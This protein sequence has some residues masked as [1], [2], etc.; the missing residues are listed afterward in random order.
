[1]LG[2]GGPGHARPRVGWRLDGARLSLWCSADVTRTPWWSGEPH[3]TGAP[4]IHHGGGRVTMTRWEPGVARPGALVPTWAAELDI[5]R[6]ALVP[7]WFG[8]GSAPAP[9]ARPYVV[10]P[11]LA[12]LAGA[13]DMHAHLGRLNGEDYA[14]ALMDELLAEAHVGRA[15]VSNLDGATFTQLEAN[16]RVLDL[17]AGRAS[18]RPVFWANPVEGLSKDVEALFADPRFAGLKFHPLL[19]DYPADDPRLDPYLALAAERGMFA[20]FHCDQEENATPERLARL[21]ARHPRVNFIAGHM[22]LWG[23]QARCLAEIRSSKAQNLYGD[24]AWFH[25]WDLLAAEIE[26][27]RDERFVFGSDAPVDGE[28]SYQQ[29]LWIL[30]R[31]GAGEPLLKRLFAENPGRLVT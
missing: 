23:A 19:N 7:V 18:L 1:M 10:S 27:G 16:R 8:A 4:V 22:G 31:M 3:H 21:A 5:G 28:E 6:G 20:L 26:A 24:L 29:Y 14:P 9:D 30:W 11:A 13:T 12:R 17:V 25:R 15:L 2:M